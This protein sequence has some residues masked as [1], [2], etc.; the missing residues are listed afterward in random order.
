MNANYVSNS[1]VGPGNLGGDRQKKEVRHVLN[2]PGMKPGESPRQGTIVDVIQ[3]RDIPRA[4]EPK[5]SYCCSTRNQV[6]L[7]RGDGI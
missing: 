4:L 7:A 3:A 1:A 6:M 5:H 2:S